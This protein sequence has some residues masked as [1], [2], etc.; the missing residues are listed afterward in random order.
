[1]QGEVIEVA[2]EK[3]EEPL[4]VD[5]STNVNGFCFEDEQDTAKEDDTTGDVEIKEG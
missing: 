5:L 2:E 1:M 3:D 4:L